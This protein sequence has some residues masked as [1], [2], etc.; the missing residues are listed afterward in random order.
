MSVASYILGIVAAV[1]V[2]VAVIEL[3][4]RRRFASGTPSGGSSPVSSL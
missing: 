2:L 1:L 3:L 4:R